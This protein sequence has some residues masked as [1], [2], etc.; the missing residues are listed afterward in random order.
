MR[1]DNDSITSK[2][3]STLFSYKSFRNTYKFLK[4]SQYW[5]IEQLREYQLEKL[6]EL[7]NHSYENVPYYRRVFDERGLKPSDIRNFKDL[8]KLPFL[9]KEIIRE[10]LEDLKAKNYPRSKFEY[11]TTGGSTGVPLGFYYE[12]GTSRAIEW[13][14]IKTLWDRVGYNF[15]DK[16]VILKGNVIKSADQ[17]K[18]WE[19]ALFGRALILS[20]YHMSEETIP[21]YINKI[22]EFGPKYIQAY[23]STITIIASFMKK[24]NIEPFPSVKALLCGSENMYP[25]QRKLLEDVLN[26][27]VYTWYGHSERVVLAGE[28]EKNKSYHIFPQYGIFEL[29]DGNGK[30]IDDFGV[31]GN[32]VGTGLTNFAMPLIR[33]KTDDLASYAGN[34]CNC[35]RSFPLITDVKGRWLQEFIIAPNYRLIPITA[36]NMHSNIFDNVVQFQFLQEKEG[37]VIFYIVKGTKYQKKDTEY[38][39]KELS[40][41]LGK[42]VKLDIRFVDKI[43]RT[44]RGK[45]RFIIQKLSINSTI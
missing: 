4:Q 23:P 5:S 20:S 36:I 26:C 11:V 19:T 44:S 2:A 15:T 13:A 24:H 34:N 7:I 8:E 28:C 6:H 21:K 32:I 31:K 35:K 27:R 40:K 17:G 45:Y 41:K 22:R 10:N 29:V 9:T 18:F 16:C 14:Y 39:R 30:I 1:F 3:L 25:D 33:Y 42:D 12:K 43:S 38:I 37:E